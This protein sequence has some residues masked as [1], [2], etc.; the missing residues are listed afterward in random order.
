MN[1]NNC[2]I[3]FTRYPEPGRTKTRLIPALGANNA[4]K[5]QR[6]MTEFT[7]SQVR[8]LQSSDRLNIEIHYTGGNSRLMSDWLGLDLKYYPQFEGDLGYKMSMAFTTAF[9]RGYRSVII[10]GTDCPSLD[11]DIIKQGFDLLESKDL[12]LGAAADGGYYLIGLHKLI[13]ELF[14]SIQWSSSEVFNVTV[15][16]ATKLNLEIGYLPTLFDID[17]P[18]DLDLIKSN[19]IYQQILF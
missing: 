10:M 19:P 5:L 11:K 1:L 2:S 6:L 4:A 13:P 17:R 7:I 8:Q 3:V 16:I 9:E 12:V 15:E 14:Q 18:E